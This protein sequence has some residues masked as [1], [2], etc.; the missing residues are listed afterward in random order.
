MTE[1]Q[2]DCRYCGK[3]ASE[4]QLDDGV[5]GR[6]CS[7]E[8]GSQFWTPKVL[9]HLRTVRDDLK[10]AQDKIANALAWIEEIIDA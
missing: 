6:L 8:H 9:L 2:F 1:T 3:P 10:A 4:H 5:N 7:L